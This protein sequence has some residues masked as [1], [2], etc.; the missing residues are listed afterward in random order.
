MKK[1]LLSLLA[2]AALV[3]SCQNYDDEFDALNAKVASLEGQI[4]SLASLQSAIA[5]VKTSVTALQSAVSAIP[6]LSSK[7]NAILADLED[8]SDAATTT[9]DLDALQTELETTLAALQALIEANKTELDALG[10]DVD[11]IL[12][13]NASFV[14][15]VTITT[16]AQLTFAKTLGTKVKSIDGNV[17]IV[18]SE[19][20]KL[21]ASDVAAVSSLIANVQG[22]VT[23]DSWKE[24][25]NMSSLTAV[26][27]NYTVTGWDASDDNLTSVS[28]QIALS[29]A[30]PYVFP[31]LTSAGTVFMEDNAK[32]AATT[33][34][35]AQSGVTSVDFLALTT[36]TSIE[37]ESDIHT[38]G[39]NATPSISTSTAAGVLSFA[40]ATSVIIGDVEVTSITAPV[41]LDVQLHYDGTQST[42]H[43]ITAVKATSVTTK[44]DE[45]TTGTD[46]Y[47]LTI[48][49]AATGTTTLTG[50]D[51]GGLVQTD[52][53]VVSAPNMIN[54]TAGLTATEATTLSFD[55]LAIGGTITAAKATSI[56]AA[57]AAITALTLKDAVSTTISAKSITTLNQ[58]DDVVSLTLASQATD[59]DLSAAT[60]LATL[61]Y[62]GAS[63]TADLTLGGAMAK[64]AT[65]SIGGK[66]GVVI[67]GTDGAAVGAS[68]TGALTVLTTFS[69]SGTIANLRVYHAKSLTSIDMQHAA[70]AINA[71]KLTV[72]GNPKLTTVK[73][74][75]DHAIELVITDNVTL[76]S[77]DASSLKTL[78]L[79]VTT[80]DTDFVFTV[81]GNHAKLA[82][83]TTDAI[84]NYTGLKGGYQAAGGAQSLAFKQNSLL[85]LKPYLVLVDAATNGADA[86][87]A[88]GSSDTISLDYIYA[89]SSTAT[90]TVSTTY[91]TAIGAGT[92]NSIGVKNEIAAIVAE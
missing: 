81:S 3:L 36:A 74:S 91:T 11:N 60:K 23:I 85:T 69:T 33:K 83:A 62:K 59:L 76:S 70:D 4:S 63:N 34:V 55:N 64:L 52:A 22:N 39:G 84:A 15:N 87:A 73:T 2:V 49:Q 29:Y 28:G 12:A 67:I 6:D 13:N 56:T 54:F 9:A 32:V 10:V 5:D 82:A 88:S 68:D 58:M 14:G 45:G 31:K 61:D 75:F 7:V 48:D 77:F 53:L 50:K 78:P 37:T 26:D 18:L 30:F 47:K 44:A 42:D 25:V 8:L 57:K 35:P 43:T 72:N 27:G 80:V 46:T 71:A 40:S 79:N 24:A 38:S 16:A 51:F 90:K 17:H 21:T 86:T 66:N 92:V 65:L 41:A 1:V 20:N 19:A 89:S